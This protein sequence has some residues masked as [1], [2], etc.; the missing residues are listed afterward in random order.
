MATGTLKTQLAT[1]IFSEASDGTLTPIDLSIMY[2]KQFSVL[3]GKRIGL[4]VNPMANI[5][6]LDAGSAI[7]YVSKRNLTRDYLGVTGTPD[8]VKQ[9]KINILLD[10]RK[11]IK[12]TV[13]SLDLAQLG[14]RY[15]DG[16]IIVSA[17]ALSNWIDGKA[18][19]VESYLF[20]KYS[21]IQVAT[22]VANTVVEL[23]IL[24]TDGVTPKVP[25]G[26]TINNFLQTNVWLPI[27]RAVA[28]FESTVNGYFIT[29]DRED[30]ALVC[31]PSAYNFLVL[32][33]STLGSEGGRNAL[34]N[35]NLTTLMDLT[36]VVN[37]F[38]G[39]NYAVGV[40]DQIEG[41]DF[42]AVDIMIVHKESIAFPYN[43][44]ISAAN[45]E[46]GTNNII[47]LHKFA[48][49]SAGG[50]AIRPTLIKGFKF[51]ASP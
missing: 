41:F 44:G 11:E 22:A 25:T 17:S 18:K 8:Q 50:G 6:Q 49:N 45:I 31:S 39:N 38:L 35:L 42:S 27:S 9:I 16:N 47:F 46:P 19:S 7:Y 23:P 43:N 12:F 36:L 34:L 26:N 40:L 1:S 37:P 4:T 10:K 28:L 29:I 48:L 5:Q 33:T 14:A 21:S 51:T 24:D 3:M 13:E 32:A 30:L 2:V 20:A 15:E